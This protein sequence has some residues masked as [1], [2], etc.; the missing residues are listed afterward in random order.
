MAW[1]IFYQTVNIGAA[2]APMMAGYLRQMDW[3]FVFI[4]CAVIIAA[5]FLLL[6]TYQE[7]GKEERLARRAAGNRESL[8]REAIT[9]LKRPVLLLYLVV[10]SGFWFMFMSLFDVMPLHIAQW[11]D[12]STIVSSIWGSDEQPGGWISKILVLDNEGTA[13][14]PE[15]IV[16][17]NA[18]MIMTSCFVFAWLSS[19]L[20]ALSSI[21]M[22]TLLC[23]AAL[24]IVGGFN[25]AWFVAFAIFI[26]STGEMIS[27]PKFSEYLGNMAPADKKAMYLGFSQL[28]LAIGGSLEAYFGPRMYGAWA[29]K[30]QISRVF[31]EG[32]GWTAEQLDAIPVGEAFYRAVEASGM[33]A[34]ALQETLYQANDIGLVWYIMGTVG[35]V[36]AF[37]MFLY[38][39]WMIRL[40][41]SIAE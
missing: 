3:Q 25:F 14:L 33:P 26:F 19:K 29:D 30:D 13:V 4:A 11:V 41:A 8:F 22:G 37:G 10:F 6:L 18:L 39:R 5:N 24:M 1:G 15:G 23:S 21:T 17:I 16:N 27:S 35:I 20:N 34:L 36:S 31:L 12:T 28:P 9:E 7:I 40:Q 32:K 2:I 38:S